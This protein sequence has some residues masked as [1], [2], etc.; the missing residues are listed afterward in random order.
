MLAMRHARLF[1]A[2]LLGAGLAGA[3]AA[4]DAPPGASPAA[5][6]A[7][8][9]WRVD[10]FHTG[11]LGAEIFALDRVVVEPLAWPGN[12]AGA[13]GPD[14]GVYRYTLSEL[15]SGKT[16]FSRGFGSIF[17]EWESTGEASKAYR[18]FHESLRFPAPAGKVRVVVEKRKDAGWREVWRLDVDPADIFID[19][20]VPPR[21]Q[22]IALER[23]GDPRDKLDLL[24]LGD[25]Y[26]ASECKR[27]FPADARRL[28]A[29]LFRHQPF[30]RRRDDV[31]VWGICPPAPASGVS[32]PSTG[33][34][35]A[36]PLG[37]SYD[38]F[39]SERYLLSFDNRA[40]RAVASWAP[41][42][43]V[44]ILANEETYGG[45]GIYNLYATVAARNDWAEYVFV[46]ELAHH[47]AGL[48]D[49]YYTSPVAYEAPSKVT[50]PWEPNVTADGKHP[51]WADLVTPGT[52]LPTPWP[53]EEYE[54]REREFQ[55]RR[56]QL[57]AA[58][59]P[60]AEMSALFREEQAFATA[61]LGKA[62]HAGEVGAF[63]GANYDALAFYRPQ[64][65]CVMYSRDEV[66]FCRVCQRALE[67]V[68]DLET[69]RLSAPSDA[70]PPP[71]R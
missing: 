66:E 5:T 22:A 60:E 30:A 21:Q 39:G 59:R 27:R 67:A 62:E 63:Q 25:G 56:K 50:E 47:L 48:A 54:A 15:A 16:L 38:A 49:E 29:A 70:A 42:E 37:T 44:A 69:G 14:A 23:H 26:T 41:Y 45:G 9:T 24:L 40:V 65:D 32:R 10:Y 33:K 2:L 51:K 28:L 7:P 46:H 19:T 68:I 20:A 12:P 35:V 17:G 71:G 8:H 58:R 1:I 43:H 36:S 3:V 55:E 4:G 53:K 64:I 31:N 18:T 57:R 11:G 6:A 52:P 61:L 13:I 34:H